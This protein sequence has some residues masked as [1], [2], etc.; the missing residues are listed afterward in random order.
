M[1]IDNQQHQ[2]LINLPILY[3]F[4]RC[5]YAMRARMALS[6]AGIACAV[7]EVALKDKPAEM[8]AISP[9]GTVPVL[10]IHQYNHAAD[11][12]LD[13]SIDIMLWA[14]KQC[15][16]EHWLTPQ[17]GNIQQM[18]A[19]IQTNDSDFKY[20]LDR[21]KY[22]DR[23]SPKEEPDKP[24]TQA[25][26]F[27][28]TLES[29]LQA[30]PYLFGIEPSLADIAIFPFGR[31]FAAVNHVWFEQTP[32]PALQQWL[33]QWLEDTRFQQVMTKQP[34]WRSGDQ[35]ELWF[36]STSPHT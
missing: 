11:L 12:I 32:L 14:L 22:P 3:S 16:S 4:R 30:S 31:Q 23:Y 21:Y 17:Q 2:A 27:L 15:Y 24:Q 25:C 9:K 19:L 1:S 34:V 36:T 29:R 10:H 6:Q 28:N 5:P 7:R 33:Q 35:P 18:L 8:L 20:H 26:T 13:E